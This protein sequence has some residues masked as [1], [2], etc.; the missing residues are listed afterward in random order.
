[1]AGTEQTGIHLMAAEAAAE[2]EGEMKGAVEVKRAVMADHMEEAAA[3]QITKII[4]I[5]AVMELT[6]LLL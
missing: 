1:M 5:L 4:I 2:G 3:E 6:A